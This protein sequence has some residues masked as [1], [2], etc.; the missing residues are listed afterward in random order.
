MKVLVASIAWRQFEAP[1][2]LS[3]F[4]LMTH[5]E[6]RWHPTLGDALIERS[7]SRAA[8]YFLEQSDADVLL[9]VDSDIDF[10]DEDAIRLAKQAMEWSSVAGI[11]VTRSQGRA[12]PT[13]RLLADVRYEFGSN[14]TPQPV[15]WPAGGFWAVHRRV[16]EAVEANRDDPAMVTCHPKHPELRLVPFYLPFLH[17]DEDGDP[18]LLSEDWAFAERARRV[19]YQHY[20]NCA[21][22]LGHWGAR[23]FTMEDLYSTEPSP[24]PLAVTRTREGYY[25][26]RPSP[27]PDLVGSS[28]TRTETRE[29]SR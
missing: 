23:R 21:I 12:I 16:F 3:L 5:E 9:T 17:T 26:E 6:T 27:T 2:V 13:T 8:T 24:S 28:G 15:Q 25:V 18:I 22:R 20:A 10:R 14:P 19:G 11:Y 29:R 1:N 4:N 7:R